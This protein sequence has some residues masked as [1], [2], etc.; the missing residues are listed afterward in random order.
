MSVKPIPADHPR[1]S[2]YLCVKDAAG[3]LAWY[4]EVLGAEEVMRIPRDDGAVMHGEL[5]IGASVVMVGEEAPDYGAFAPGHFGGTAVS[6]MLYVADVDAAFAR[7]LDAGAREE[8]PPA[9]QPFGDRVGTLLDPFG[10]RWHLA[11]RLEEVS[12]E[13]MVRRMSGGA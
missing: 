9:D 2:P 7:A 13:E 3:A 5:R 1:L 12:V 4:A 8:R 10:H 6:L 11:S